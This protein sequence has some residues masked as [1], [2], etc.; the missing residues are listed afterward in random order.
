[1]KIG[2]YLKTVTGAALGVA[3]AVFGPMDAMFYGLVFCIV[4]DY[5][6][7]ICAAVYNK[8]LDSRTGFLGILK[9][10]VILVVVALSYRVG[11]IAGVTAIRDVVIGFYIANEGLSILENAARMNIKCME[12]LKVFLA[13]IGESK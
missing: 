7:G 1:M 4:A 12:K 3:S 9:K 13:Q 5:I 8:S 10:I 6:T 2:L 11:E